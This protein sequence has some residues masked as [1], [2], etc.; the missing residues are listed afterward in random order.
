MKKFTGCFTKIM[1]FDNMVIA[2]LS[3]V[4]WRVKKIHYI[5]SSV[6][7]L[8]RASTD[9]EANCYSFWYLTVSEGI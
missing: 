6:A 3:P 4:K 2:V 9:A 5:A 7:S 1:F 8:D